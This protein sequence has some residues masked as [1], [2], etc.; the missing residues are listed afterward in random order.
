V[1]PD[2]LV[3]GEDWREKGVVGAEWVKEHGGEVQLVKLRSGRSTSEII[4][5]IL[6]KHGAGES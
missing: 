3:K 6:D 5:R 2:I 4:R 1:T